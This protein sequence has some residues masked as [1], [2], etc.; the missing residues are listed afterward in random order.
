MSQATLHTW[1]PPSRRQY[2]PKPLDPGQPITWTKEI[3]G[4]W[5]G[6]TW[7]Q[8]TWIPS[9]TVNRIGVIWSDGPLPSSVW[10][11]PDD[12]NETVAVK[13]PTL[14]MVQRGRGPAEMPSYGP[15]WQ[16]AAP[17]R[18]NHVAASGTVYAVV[19][20]TRE[21]YR[22]GYRRGTEEIMLWHCDPECPDAAS[23]ERRPD[24]LGYGY[25]IKTVIDGLIGR[26]HPH[27]DGAWCRRCIWLD[28][29]AEVEPV[30]ETAEV[31][32]Q[33]VTEVEPVTIVV[34]AEPQPIVAVVAVGGPA[35]LRI[36]QAVSTASKPLSGPE[37][38]VLAGISYGTARVLLHKLTRRGLLSQ[39][40]RGLYSAPDQISE[41]A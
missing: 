23:K 2:N 25:T 33:A 36:V 24:R 3:P 39:P 22:H 18:A 1:K 31:E 40:R 29:L 9:E 7:G 38:A 28:E 5:T 11:Q 6:A 21:S 20:E 41:V 35:Q 16:Q 14:K 15:D 19:N 30:N 26:T 32:V 12:V 34:N 27:S 13:L 10:V 4:R 8:G 17:R 37:I